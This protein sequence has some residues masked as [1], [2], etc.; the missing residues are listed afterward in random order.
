MVFLRTLYP[1]TI[2]FT[3]WV[4]ISQHH[5]TS[6]VLIPKATRYLQSLPTADSFPSTVAWSLKAWHGFK[7]SRKSLK[8]LQAS[9]SLV[10]VLSESVCYSL[11]SG[12]HVYTVEIFVEFATDI[13]AVHPTKHVT[14][15][16]SRLRLL[17]R[18]DEAMHTESNS[19]S[20]LCTGPSHITL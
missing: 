4:P 12:P 5:W 16:H 17:P 7:S 19:L 8:T 3:H 15:L 14:L 1:S 9:L 2:L 13:A 10:V 6:G 18:F 11:L 20:Q